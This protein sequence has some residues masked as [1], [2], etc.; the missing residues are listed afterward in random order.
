MGK[1]EKKKKKVKAQ[2]KHSIFQ[3]AP[4]PPSPPRGK[5]KNTLGVMP[6]NYYKRIGA[7]LY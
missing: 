5:G 7:G 3:N 4:R 2:N 1:N 6:S